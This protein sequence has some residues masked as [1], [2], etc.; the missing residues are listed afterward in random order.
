MSLKIATE[1][2]SREEMRMITGGSASGC[3]H[4]LNCKD[5]TQISGRSGPCPTDSGG[6]CQSNGGIDTCVQAGC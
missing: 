6:G 2:L 3:I 5:G 1:S 4:T